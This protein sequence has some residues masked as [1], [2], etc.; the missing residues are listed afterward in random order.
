VIFVADISI[1]WFTKT[2]SNLT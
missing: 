2:Y 1:Y